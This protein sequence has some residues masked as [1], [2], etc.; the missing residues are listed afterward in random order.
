VL[1]LEILRRYDSH[2]SQEVFVIPAK[3]GIHPLPAWMPASAGMTM[4]RKN[5]LEAAT[6]Y[7]AG[8][9]CSSA[10]CA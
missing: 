8:E 4:E 7:I 9:H 5:H 6:S 10:V 1:S 3:A 2:E